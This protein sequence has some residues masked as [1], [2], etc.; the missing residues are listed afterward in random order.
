M[1]YIKTLFILYAFFLT[2]EVK[3]DYVN[4][5]CTHD[6]NDSL[7]S[8]LINTGEKSVMMKE[9]KRPLDAKSNP[10][11]ITIFSAE[12]DLDVLVWEDPIII[13]NS[14]SDLW[15]Y[16]YVFDLEKSV[17]AELWYHNPKKE[18]PSINSEMYNCLT[19]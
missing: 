6:R 15:H 9:I 19:V 11:G 10:E 18:V 16:I 8:F 13:A 12:E 14:E 5:V 1:G 2:L 3:A 7:T 4:Y 17:V